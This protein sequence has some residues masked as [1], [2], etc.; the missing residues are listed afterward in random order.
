M[1]RP[2]SQEPPSP[3]KARLI[4]MIRR[5]KG[6]SHTQATWRSQ[7]QAAPT[8]V[9]VEERAPSTW[10]T[11][12]LL[13][14]CV[15]GYVIEA[16]LGGGFFE[17]IPRTE[18]GM[19][20][21]AGMGAIWFGGPDSPLHF[22]QQPWRL[23]TYGFMHG[24]L[25]HLLFNAMALMQIGPL[26]E[27]SF[28]AARTLAFWVLTSALSIALPA[29]LTQGA[30]RMTVGA[31]GAIFGLIGVA[32]AYGHRVGTAQGHVIRNKMIEWTVICTLF[33]M[34]MGNVAHEAH[35]GG[36]LSGAALSF[37]LTPPKR[38]SSRDPLASLLL[39]GGALVIL[40]ACYEAY[41]FSTQVL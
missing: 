6:E 24:G 25:M 34:M 3:L 29:L 10:V 31:S 28:G 23:I 19:R 4:Y 1:S 5:L 22:T 36:L 35:F 40:W 38:F 33:G 11:Q 8:Y 30:T 39:M 26:I 37:V 16:G 12:S 2:P 21:L 18:Q 27:R 13:A 7:H 41:L 15:L 17:P 20:M 9:Y 14:L 32:M